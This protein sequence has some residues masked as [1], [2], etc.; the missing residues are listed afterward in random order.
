MLSGKNSQEDN[1]NYDDGYR[2][3]VFFANLNNFFFHFFGP[4]GLRGFSN[5]FLAGKS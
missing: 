3:W 4:Y 2:L 1:Y 5:N